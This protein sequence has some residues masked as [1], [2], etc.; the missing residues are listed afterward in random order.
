MNDVKSTKKVEDA[1]KAPFS[2]L[3]EH[4]NLD[5][6]LINSNMKAR[7]NRLRQPSVTGA[8]SASE[9]INRKILSDDL[10]FNDGNQADVD[11]AKSKD[12]IKQ[13]LMA[14]PTGSKIVEKS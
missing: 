8:S 10:L 14:D 7:K 3:N 11:L 4:Y 2:Q 9:E 12:K 6:K 1:E 5:L 13:K